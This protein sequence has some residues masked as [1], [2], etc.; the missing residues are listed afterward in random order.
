MGVVRSV[1]IRAGLLAAGFLFG[2]QGSAFGQANDTLA[3]VRQTAEA[4]AQALALRRVDALQPRN[5]DVVSWFEWERLRLDL[6]AATGEDKAV[7]ERVRAYPDGLLLKREALALLVPAAHAALRSKEPA[8]ARHWL[9]RWFA[10]AHVDAEN[11]QSA[12]YRRARRLVIEALLVEGTSESAYRAMLRFQQD[13][14]PLS[15]DETEGFVAGLLRLNRNSEAAQWLTQL[16]PRSHYAALLRMRAGL[17]STDAAAAQ[18]RATLAK[19]NDPAALDLLDAAVRAQNDRAGLVEVAESRLNLETTS[20][21]PGVRAEDVSPVALWRTYEE[22]ALFG[23]NQ[24]Q[25]LVGD[26]NGWLAHSNRIRPQQPSMSRALLA[27]LALKAT[28]ERMRA[29]AQG[30]LVTALMDARL[31]RVAI[32][33]FADPTLFRIGTMDPHLRFVLGEINASLGRAEQA[34]SYWRGL[35]LP[36]GLTGEQWR[37]Y[38]LTVHAEADQRAEVQVA[39]SELLDAN[40]PLSDEIRKRLFDVGRTALAR[41]QLDIAEDVLLRLRARVENAERAAVSMALAQV[42]EST[43]RWH[44][45]ADAHL[46]AAM[47]SAAPA[48]DRD[49]LHA[50][51]SAARSLSRVGMREDARRI[52]EWLL[53]NAKDPTVRD[54]AQRALPQRERK[55]SSFPGR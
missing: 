42:Y 54:S 7:V 27:Y 19:S 40:R 47:A 36:A 1:L 53:R 12:L 15:A 50:R 23:A 6:L 9:H 14:A 3:H 43:G 37:M 45:A 52:Y 49:S 16:S 26:E 39:A 8:Q 30:R 21:D 24:A 46:D 22:A 48:S 41:G 18:A 44:E 32:I 31:E 28:S 5:A 10:N 33:L 2:L 17:M 38:R 55:L 4:G 29:D 34:A 13:F 25:L 51:L 35:A 20:E 11:L